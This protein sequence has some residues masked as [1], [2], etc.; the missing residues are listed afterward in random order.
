MNI[1]Q[2][3][4][5][6]IGSLVAI[7]L[8]IMLS[9]YYLN[10]RNTSLGLLFNDNKDTVKL[11]PL[12]GDPPRVLTT[13]LVPT[14]KPEQ[15]QGIDIT[16]QGVQDSTGTINGLEP[17][18]PYE[19]ELTTSNGVNVTVFIPQKDL[20]ENPW[21]LTVHTYGINFN[22]SQGSDEYNEMKIAFRETVN[23]VFEFIKS[24]NQDPQRVLFRWGD[25][26]FMQTQA[27]EWLKK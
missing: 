19:K 26:E 24:K 4:K 27:E 11:Q 18:L 23:H 2:H 7:L 25:K 9:I 3:K 5:I 17:V 20:Q 8:V 1:I 6:I 21:T 12:P 22:A 13:S 14:L 10:N 16:S 15:G